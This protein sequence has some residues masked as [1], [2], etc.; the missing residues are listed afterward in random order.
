M[1]ETL[2]TAAMF[3]D[4]F[5]AELAKAKLEAEGIASVV[6]EDATYQLYGYATGGVRLEVK[7]SEKER[8]LQVLGLTERASKAEVIACSMEGEVAR[9]VLRFDI[10]PSEPIVPASIYSVAEESD[11]EFDLHKLVDVGANVVTFE[12]YDAGDI[13]PEIGATYIFRPWWEP[14]Q[15]ELVKD[16]SIVW[17]REKFEPTD[18]AQHE[19]CRLCW[20]E[21]S[22]AEAESEFG[23]TDATHWICERCY[24]KYIASGMREK[25]G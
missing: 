7:G 9:T 6:D 1:D 18:A 19:E 11:E 4:T 20:R 21:I 17:H 23:Y 25:L 5:Q 2:V 15:I 13:H 22:T 3:A 16:E 14:E 12:T 24:E 10:L 8:A